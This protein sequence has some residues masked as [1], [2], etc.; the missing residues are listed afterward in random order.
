[1]REL[2]LEKTIQ[3]AIESTPVGKKVKIN[4]RGTPQI[5]DVEMSFAGGWVLTQTIIPG[6]PLEFIRGENQ[7]LNSI[8]I[9]IHPYNGLELNV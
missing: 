2:D 6:K 3:E 7:Y 4:F 8:R 5:I 1:M 9:N